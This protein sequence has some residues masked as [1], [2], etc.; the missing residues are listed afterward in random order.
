MWWREIIQ[1]E[2]RLKAVIKTVSYGRTELSSIYLS[3]YLTHLICHPLIHAHSHTLTQTHTHAQTH[4]LSHTRTTSHYSSQH[5]KTLSFTFNENDIN[6]SWS[7]RG[8]PSFS[9]E[10]KRFIYLFYNYLYVYFFSH[11][12]IIMYEMLIS[13]L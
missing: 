3:L 9:E 12:S 1:I 10:L 11:Y 8:H 2:E 4:T 13:Y 7:T 5:N 6:I